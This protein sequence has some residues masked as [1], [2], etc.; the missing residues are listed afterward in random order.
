MSKAAIMKCFSKRGGKDTVEDD[1]EVCV[2][3]VSIPL[4]C[5]LDMKLIATPAKGRF[6]KH[7]QCFSLENFILTTETVHPRKWRCNICKAKCY[8]IVV[9][10]FLLDIINTVKSS[11]MNNV[12]DVKFD[13][14][15]NHS[16]A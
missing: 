10:L 8:D 4:T 6:C 16:F 12:V 11:G 2:D 5:S 14:S 3:S 15:G 13:A 9:D 1:D 7:L